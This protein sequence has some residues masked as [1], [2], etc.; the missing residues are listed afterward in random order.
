MQQVT[1]VDNSQNI[2]AS[3]MS[4]AASISSPLTPPL[5]LLSCSLSDELLS[6]PTVMQNTF[7]LSQTTYQIIFFS[8]NEAISHF[9]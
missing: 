5:L 2:V 9:G 4:K 3:L 1:N 6:I 8:L 7:F